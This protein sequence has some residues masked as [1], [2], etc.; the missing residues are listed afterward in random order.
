[1]NELWFYYSD[2]GVDKEGNPLEVIHTM[3]AELQK[4]AGR[5]PSDPLAF[6]QQES[7]FGNLSGNN[8]FS[9]LYTSCI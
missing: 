6:I 1:M 5:S 3:A 4:H 8:R 9:K 7:L 2:R